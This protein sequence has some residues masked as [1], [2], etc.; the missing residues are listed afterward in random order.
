MSK[1]HLLAV[2]LLFSGAVNASTPKELSDEASSAQKESENQVMRS[3][4]KSS[5][6]D[7]DRNND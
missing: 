4:K 7:D 6:A 2:M 1:L 5:Q 3:S